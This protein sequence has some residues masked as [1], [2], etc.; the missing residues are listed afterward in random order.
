MS[1]VSTAPPLII[2]PLLGDWETRRYDFHW[3]DG[4]LPEPLRLHR[5]H[6]QDALRH[7]WTGLVAGTDGGVRWRDERMSAGYVVGADPVPEKELAVRVGGP[8]STL[9][10]EAAGLLQ[11]LTQ[12]NENQQAPL[13]VFMDSLVLLDILQKWGQANF[14]PLPSDIIHFDVIFPLLCAL[15]QWQHPVRLVKVK[16]HT[17]CLMNERADELAERGYGENVQ[18]VCSAL[19]SMVPSG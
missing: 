9:R 2:P 5:E 16:S 8:L 15:R 1:Q 11:L 7:S 6:Q 17:G 12:L 13:L 10:A 4:Q 3:H 18:E 19:R 14:N